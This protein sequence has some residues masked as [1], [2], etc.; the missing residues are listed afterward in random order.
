MEGK[1]ECVCDCQKYSKSKDEML[2]AV[3]KHRDTAIALKQ[4]AD[5]Q[6]KKLNE[7]RELSNRMQDDIDNLEDEVRERHEFATKVSMEKKTLEN[8]IKFLI[9]KLDLK[10]EDIIRLE[11]NLEKQG[12]LSQ[13][14]LKS[15]MKDKEAL[16]EQLDLANNEK[17]ENETQYK[18][19]AN[20]EAE[21]DQMQTEIN[22]LVEDITK[23]QVENKGKE[24]LLKD[25]GGEN[26]MLS[27]KIRNLEEKIEEKLDIE[28][29]ET[30]S[31]ENELSLCDK[32][33]FT[34]NSFEC[35]ECDAKFSS[36][37]DLRKHIKMCH[38]SEMKLKLLK[39]ERLFSDQR[40][41]FA[42]SLI[43]LQQQEAIKKQKPC[44]CRGFCR[45]NHT[46]HHWKLSRCDKFFSKLQ[47]MKV[48]EPVMTSHSCEECGRTF[49][50]WSDLKNHN[51]SK[52]KENLSNN[53]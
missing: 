33:F 35:T 3:A 48:L 36:K 25:L 8:E 51:E 30:R 37:D 1:K 43:K 16:N 2:E 22:K 50:N 34:A 46:K 12:A 11:F 4:V 27:E 10:N 38:V 23:L 53:F 44:L 32:D 40:T 28:K 24:T 29:Y 17:V 18:I 13:K 9:E 26:E 47:E 5:N 21:K 45:I 15:L 31:I 49:D 19:K 6:K 7:Y 42:T 52:H 39:A 14:V 20:N 41:N